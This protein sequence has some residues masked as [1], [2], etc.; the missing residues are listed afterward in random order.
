MF[1][2]LLCNGEVVEDALN[3]ELNPELNPKLNPKLNSSV[4]FKTWRMR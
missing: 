2:R 3:P 1:C 4:M